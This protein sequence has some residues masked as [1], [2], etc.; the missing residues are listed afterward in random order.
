M[1]T[2][3]TRG[4]KATCTFIKF[5]ALI[6]PSSATSSKS[7]RENPY[8]QWQILLGWPENVTALKYGYGEK[9]AGKNHYECHG[10]E[11]TEK[12]TNTRLSIIPQ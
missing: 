8:S 5:P 12:R 7:E 11:E 2:K 4:F 3:W 9:T 6:M 10:H 1:H